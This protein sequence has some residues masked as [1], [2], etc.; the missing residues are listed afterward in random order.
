MSHI[1]S[2][3]TEVR[4]AAA[5]RAACKRLSLAE[6]VKGKT[7]LFS[8]EVS[9]LA[10]KLP[11]SQYPVVADISTGQLKFDNF[12]GLWGDQQ[13]LDR[14]LQAYAYEKAKIEARKRGHTVT[15]Q[16]LSDGSIKLTIQVGGG[17][18]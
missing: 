2:I 13:H 9:G 14:F 12:N 8:G 16:Q 6:P 15:E 5:V 7:R 3:Q 18:A 10:V 11:D 1:V 4:D 17:A